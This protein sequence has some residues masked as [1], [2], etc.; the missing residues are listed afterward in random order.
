M[1]RKNNRP[2][3]RSATTIV[4]ENGMITKLSNTLATTIAGAVM[5][6]H[7]SANG[8]IQSSLKNNFSVSAS[9]IR[10][11]S[12]PA[13]FGPSLSCHKASS[14]RSTQISPAAIFSNTN[15]TPKTIQTCCITDI[16]IILR[17]KIQEPR[18]KEE[19]QKKKKKTKEISIGESQILT[20]KSWILE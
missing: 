11:P 15:S 1:A 17:S 18:S 6:T 9:T 4:G 12:G 20:S 5:N 3:F 19:N 7:L 2:R 8:G 14:L 16:T 10:I 13:R